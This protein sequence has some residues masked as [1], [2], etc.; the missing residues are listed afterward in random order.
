M[1]VF[2][3]LNGREITLGISESY[4]ENQNIINYFLLIVK[5]R[6]RC[7]GKIPHLRWYLT[8]QLNVLIIWCLYADFK[9]LGDQN[10]WEKSCYVASELIALNLLVGICSNFDI[11]Y[12]GYIQTHCQKKKKIK[13]AD[14]ILPEVYGTTLMEVLHS[15]N[16]KKLHLLYIPQTEINFQ[17]WL[18]V[19]SAMN[20]W[21]SFDTYYI[22]FVFLNCLYE[23]NI[24]FYICYFAYCS[25]YSI[26]YVL[27]FI[28][29]TYLY[30]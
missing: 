22:I 13:R 2:V 21:L 29:I 23:N 20:G 26:V 18:N 11:Y 30:F 28:S 25:S 5:C 17:K 3:L 10:H 14:Q 12:S 6:C 1:P 4:I 27:N 7:N 9:H 8:L 24:S 19:E 15:K 16:R